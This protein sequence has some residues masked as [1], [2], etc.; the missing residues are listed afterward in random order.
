MAVWTHEL[1]EINFNWENF[2][3]SPR[4]LLGLSVWLS[5]MIDSNCSY[6]Y[7]R[8]RFAPSLGCLAGEAWGLRRHTLITGALWQ[9]QLSNVQRSLVIFVPIYTLGLALLTLSVLW[10]L[11]FRLRLKFM[12]SHVNNGR[13]LTDAVVKCSRQMWISVRCM[14][15]KRHSI[16]RRQIAE[17]WQF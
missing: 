5:N 8:G 16:V 7:S 13:T 1:M 6:L 2:S 15:G 17:I 12:T 9:M 14:Y 4:N 11:N 10:Q 3:I